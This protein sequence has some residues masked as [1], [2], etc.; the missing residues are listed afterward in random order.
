MFTVCITRL[1]YISVHVIPKPSQDKGLV[2]GWPSSNPPK[3]ELQAVRTR[4]SGKN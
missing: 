4:M 3:E 2:V 1:S